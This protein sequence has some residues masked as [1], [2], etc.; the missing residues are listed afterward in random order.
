MSILALP[1]LFGCRDEPT[2][3]AMDPVVSLSEETAGFTQEHTSEFPS[4]RRVDLELK[5]SGAFLPGA[6]VRID[7][8]AR[9]NRAAANVFYEL[10]VLDDDRAVQGPPGAVRRP[11]KLG[12]WRGSLSER[13]TQALSGMVTFSRPGYYRVF[14]RLTSEPVA[15]EKPAV[16][17]RDTLVF[18]GSDETLWILIDETGGRLTEG[19]D[20]TA[21]FGT[22]GRRPR[23]GTYGPFVAP[24]EEPAPAGAAPRTSAAVDPAETAASF[25][26]EGEPTGGYHEPTWGYVYHTNLET[27]LVEPLADVEIGVTCEWWWDTGYYENYTRTDANGY[28]YIT[29]PETYPYYKFQFV[30]VALHSYYLD[31][32]GKDGATAGT[33][34]DYVSGYKEI[35]VANDHA[36]HAFKQLNAKVS[37]AEQ[38]FGRYARPV[39]AYVSHNDPS[40]GIYY[41]PGQSRIYT[42]YT[43]LT[44]QD[45]WFVTIHEYGHHFQEKSIEAAASYSCTNNSHGW[46]ET[47]NLSCAYSE[48]FADFF[49]MWVAGDRLSTA[50][51][52]GDYGIENNLDGYPYG[53]PTNPPYA[54]D[55]VRVEA[56]LGAFLYDMVDGPNEPDSPTNTAGGEESWDVVSYSGSWIAD[57]MQ[58]CKPGGQTKL[59]GP[60]QMVYCLEGSAASARTE[61]LRWSSVWRAY[62]TISW[63]KTITHY[64]PSL[65]R[66]LW[67][68]NFYG[69][70]E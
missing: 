31:V 32:R 7:A 13:A 63:D 69:V 6:P 34:V 70:L 27:G 15:G 17:R 43:R 19:F 66:R 37:T 44:G 57:V 12:D 53:S 28:F 56:A 50:P 48:G 35:R 23:Y 26:H 10:V 20:T 30:R 49:A 41:S 64:E 42:N 9:A 21:A 55:G 18:N 40:Y 14:A 3:P 25:D 4:I 29:C 65:I 33:P 60:D 52:G 5:A 47:E 11:A 58:Y 62:S 24:G 54:G 8:V 22:P 68:Y 59:D 45:G 39:S 46:T 36:A 67:K 2:A 16:P 38:R 61:S 1:L 51:Y